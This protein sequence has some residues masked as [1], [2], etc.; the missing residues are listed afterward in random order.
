MSI[1]IDEKH[2][3]GGPRAGGAFRKDVGGEH[4]LNE[5]RPEYDVRPQLGDESV[6]G[7]KTPGISTAR[8]DFVAAGSKSGKVLSSYGH[9]WLASF[10][11]CDSISASFCI[12]RP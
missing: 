12:D 8:A 9:R 10:L 4:G 2:P 7:Y 5:E 1:A 3:I 6:K 11:A